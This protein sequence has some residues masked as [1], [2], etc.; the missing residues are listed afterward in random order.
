MA[1]ICN[2]K[3]DVTNASSGMKGQTGV[4]YC[5]DLM[6]NMGIRNVRANLDY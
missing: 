1:V 6:T 4:R 2:L 5:S 3:G